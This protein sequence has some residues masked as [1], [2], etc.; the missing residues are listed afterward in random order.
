MNTGQACYRKLKKYKY[1]LVG[2]PYRIQTAIRPELDVDT[3]YIKLEISGLLTIKVHYAWDGPS[4]PTI[5]T[6][7]FMRGSLVHDA[8][9]Q[10]MR[11]KKLNHE[12]H[13]E[14][15][16]NLLRDVCRQ[17]GMSRFRSWYVHKALRRFG[18]KHARK[19]MK[20]NDNTFCVPS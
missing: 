8:L 3:R 12:E 6:K 10:L 11:Q 13:R 4:G 7:T 9:Y 14:A 20:P 15:A 18:E 2:E 5:D 19:P 1:Q 17:D 16:D